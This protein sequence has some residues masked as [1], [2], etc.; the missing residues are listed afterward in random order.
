[1]SEAGLLLGIDT[2]GVEGSL[3]LASVDAHATLTLIAETMLCGRNRSAELV[4]QLKKMLEEA[5]ISLSK[6]SAVVVVHGPGS[7][8]G[9]RIGI[10]AAKALAEAGT[11]P[12]IAVSKLVML[13]ADENCTASVLDAGRGELYLR[14]LADGKCVESIET[15]SSVLAMVEGVTVC[16]C[17]PAVVDRLPGLAINLV[18]EP[19]A[20]DALRTAAP[21]FLA[22][23]F[24]DVVTLDANYV[25]HPYATVAS[26]R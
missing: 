6:I 15:S 25:R 21:R 10:S 24:D 1:M 18:A 14:R 11:V 23:D 12:F 16:A 13:S 9:L 2:S 4:P 17:E 19:K 5:K 22:A 8:T 26:A 7:F 3:A 20:I